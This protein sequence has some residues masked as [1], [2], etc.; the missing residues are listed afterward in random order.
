MDGE[1]KLIVSGQRHSRCASF[2]CVGLSY[3]IQVQG[4]SADGHGS[5]WGA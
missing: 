1:M 5:L 4:W 2:H 3:S